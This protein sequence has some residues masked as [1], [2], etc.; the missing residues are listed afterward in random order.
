MATERARILV[1]DDEEAFL[2]IVCQRLS[3]IG[4]ECH[5]ASSAER[6]AELLRDD[7][8]DLM[9]LDILMPEKSG[10]DFLRESLQLHPNLAVAMVSAVLDPRVAREARQ[11]GAIDFLKK[12]MSLDQLAMRVDLMLE[13]R[14]RQ[15][16]PV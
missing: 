6:A 11:I 13:W 9:L 16:P 15:E 14:R 3:R 1:V 4:H 12:P 2:E 10:M 7:G 5:T 8:I